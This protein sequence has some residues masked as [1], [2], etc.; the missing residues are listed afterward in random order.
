MLSWLPTSGFLEIFDFHTVWIPFSILIN[1]HKAVE[2][3]G[4]K[5]IIPALSI[6]DMTM[7]K[8]LDTNNFIYF[9]HHGLTLV[10]ICVSTALEIE[11]VTPVIP[12]GDVIWEPIDEAIDRH[13]LECIHEKRVGWYVGGMSQKKRKKVKYD[14]S[15][16]R[17]SLWETGLFLL[18]HLMIG[19]SRE[20][21]N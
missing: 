21:F 14:E 6:M 11:T 2:L 5:L 10:C 16:P 3:P 1:F 13:D 4:Y 18:E 7:K 17:N 20:H 15:M 8:N 9:Y 19:S 12:P